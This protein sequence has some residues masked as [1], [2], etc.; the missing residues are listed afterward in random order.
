VAMMID[1]KQF[2]KHSLINQKRNHVDVTQKRN[3]ALKKEERKLAKKLKKLL[4][5][6]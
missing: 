2:L 5:K 6:L 3:A 1:L 4:I